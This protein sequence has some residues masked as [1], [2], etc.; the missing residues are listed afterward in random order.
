M[1]Q[2]VYL[3]GGFVGNWVIRV[4]SKNNN[5]SWIDPK[6][7]EPMGSFQ[8][9]VKWDLHHIN[10]CDILFAYVSKSNRSCIGLAV[11]VGYAKGLGKTVILVLEP[12]HESINDRHLLF[13]A[14]TA[15]V[16]FSDLESGANYLNTFI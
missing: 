9:Y 16:V 5:L 7:K 10:Q 6:E 1:K 13:L 3:A 15:D 11:E 14:G 4:T 2:K 8:E 12:Y